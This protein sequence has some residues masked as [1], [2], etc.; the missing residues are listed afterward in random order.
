MAVRVLLDTNAYSRFAHRHEQVTGTI[1][2][3]AEEVLFSAIVMGELLTGFHA[4][5]RFDQNVAELRA[6]L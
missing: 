2:E 6:F 3:S 5:S 1:V 4:G